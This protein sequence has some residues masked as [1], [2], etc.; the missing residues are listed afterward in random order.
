MRKYMNSL[1]ILAISFSI[2][3]VLFA[4]DNFEGKIKFKITYE[5]E[6]NFL[7][8]FI[9]GNNLRMEMGENAEAVFIKTEDKSLVLMP[10]EEMYMDLNNSILSKLPG[11]SGMEDNENDVEEDFDIDKYKTGKTQNILG[12]ECHQWIFSD[13]EED[14]EV[15]AW[16]TSELGNFML[17]QSPMGAGYSPGW[18]SSVKN[19]GFF[20]L[21]VITRDEDGEENSR[22]E[23]TEINKQSLGDGLFGP[24]SNYNEMKIPGMDNLF[25]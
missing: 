23:A 25:K 16:V 4:Q 11:M 19:N 12:Y 21:L 7:D 5:D 1:I 10:E 15:E 24:P 18:S 13:E 3:S 22:F 20:P 2:N 9:K 17:M 6:V 14:D 8:Y